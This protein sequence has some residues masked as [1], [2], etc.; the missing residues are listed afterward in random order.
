MNNEAAGAMKKQ[1]IIVIPIYKELTENEKISF[2][3]VLKI[4]GRYD[5]C[6][7]LPD[8]IELSWLQDVCTK[9]VCRQE[10]FEKA[11]FESVSTYNQLML[12]EQF[13]GRFAEYEYMLLYQLD[14]FVF[15][16]R[17]E[18]FCLLGYDYIGAPWL[19]G[20][21]AVFQKQWKRCY[22]GNGGFSLRRIERVR[23]LLKKQLCYEEQNEDLFFAAAD[24]E[25]RIAPIEI[26]LQFSFERQVRA[27]YERNQHELPFGCHAWERYDLSFWKPFIEQYGYFIK[28][29]DKENTMDI[30]L[31]AL[32]KQ[33]E[34]AGMIYQ[35]ICQYG[36]ARYLKEQF[37][38]PE[39]EIVIWGA[40][41]IGRK[42]CKFLVYQGIKVRYVIDNAVALQGSRIEGIEVVGF[43]KIKEDARFNMIIAINQYRKEIADQLEATVFRYREN[44][45][46]W[47][48]VTEE[49]WL[50]ISDVG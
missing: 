13:Y 37:R 44:Y 33:K 35:Y 16:D 12:T 39:K 11:Y 42:V 17:L 24:K 30:A 32:Y 31:N 50:N 7:V 15:S 38:Y 28:E 9:G 10:Y 26:A 20:E 19:C 46:F 27:C 23:T 5:I 43:E 40:G 8:G 25:L 2:R 34:T 18:Y 49:I 47:D 14:A 6:L 29:T 41:Y 48:D 4:L 1:V 36:W 45:I 3:Q 22:V 21:L